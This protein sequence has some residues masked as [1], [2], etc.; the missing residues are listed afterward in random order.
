VMTLLDD[1]RRRT[2]KVS[3]RVHLINQASIHLGN[4][5]GHLIV[6]GRKRSSRKASKK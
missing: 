1:L 2:S 6:E 3:H 5:V 4:L